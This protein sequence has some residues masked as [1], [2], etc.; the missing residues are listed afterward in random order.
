MRTHSCTSKTT[1]SPWHYCTV[2]EWLKKINKW[3]W[4]KLNDCTW[5][6]IKSVCDCAM[7]SSAK[8]VL[9]IT[10]SNRFHPCWC[11]VSCR[12][13]CP[14]H[15]SAFLVSALCLT[16]TTDAAVP[17]V[18]AGQAAIWAMQHY[19]SVLCT[20]TPL[21]TLGTHVQHW[22]GSQTNHLDTCTMQVPKHRHV[23]PT[24]RTY[25]SRNSL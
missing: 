10:P 22:Q 17:E 1:F 20:V 21:A 15:Q 7:H 25:R 9:P 6:D 2:E 5:K 11:L 16:A 12:P 8:R 18:E 13:S 19:K 23:A 3:K 24:Y 4:Q 14:C